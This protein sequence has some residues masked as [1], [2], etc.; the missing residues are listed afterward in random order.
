MYDVSQ[1]PSRL[2]GTAVQPDTFRQW[3]DINND[4]WGLMSTA[5]LGDVWRTAFA[6][7]GGA[8][9]LNIWR[10]PLTPLCWGISRDKR[11]RPLFRLIVW[12]TSRTCA[13]WE[14][15]SWWGKMR[16]PAPRWQ[17]CSSRPTRFAWQSRSTRLTATAPYAPEPWDAVAAFGSLVYARGM[18]VNDI[19]FVFHYIRSWH[20]VTTYPSFLLIKEWRPANTWWSRHFDGW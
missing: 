14:S 3:W 16:C 7:S 9:V 12:S 18:L 6:A 17:I 13:F 20:V 10:T 11:T 19:W 1:L 2:E 5:W 15:G 8:L 4:I